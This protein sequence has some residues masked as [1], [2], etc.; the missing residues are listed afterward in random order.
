MATFVS[1]FSGM[2]L[3]M[4]ASCVL[5][6]FATAGQVRA[7]EMNNGP[8][9]PVSSIAKGSPIAGHE[10]V[11]YYLEIRPQNLLMKLIQAG[12]LRPS[13]AAVPPRVRRKFPEVDSKGFDEDIFDEGF[14]D[15][16]T[17]RRKKGVYFQ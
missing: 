2:V 11:P 5:L 15:F 4:L 10:D 1:S 3:L 14:G 17:M 9:A 16:S 7:E 13:I 12:Y 6:F 8:P